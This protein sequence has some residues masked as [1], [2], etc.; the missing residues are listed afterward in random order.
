M[1]VGIARTHIR[2]RSMV[3]WWAASVVVSCTS[4]AEMRESPSKEVDYH[5]YGRTWRYSTVERYTKRWGIN[6]PHG[7]IGIKEALEQSIYLR[8]AEETIPVHERIYALQKN[9]SYKKVDCCNTPLTQAVVDN[10]D[11]KLVLY[12]KQ[13]RENVT[14]CFIHP[15]GRP[16]DEKEP[17]PEKRVRYIQLFGEFDPDKKAFYVRDFLPGFSRDEFQQK[18]GSR[19]SSEQTHR[20]FYSNRAPFKC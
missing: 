16:D 5:A 7:I 4:C 13:T 2:M 11:G 8:S 1:N 12:F 15:E 14:D 18:V 20:F 10:F 19:G 6:T 9:G 17:D 3:V